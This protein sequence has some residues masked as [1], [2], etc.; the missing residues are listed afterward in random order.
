MIKNISLILLILFI[1]SQQKSR[2]AELRSR[3]I[4]S[5]EERRSQ[6]RSYFPERYE[7]YLGADGTPNYRFRDA[8]DSYGPELPFNINI[9]ELT[10]YPFKRVQINHKLDDGWLVG[11]NFGEWGGGLFWFNE[12]GDEH[13]RLRFGTIQRIISIGSNVYILQGLDQV[14]GDGRILKLEKKDRWTVNTL[15]ELNDTPYASFI[16]EN[17]ELIIAATENIILVNTEFEAEPLIENGF[18]KYY[19]APNSVIIH[20]DILYVGMSEG[21]LK[22]PLNNLEKMEWLTK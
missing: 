4:P 12:S 19:A 7:V 13:Y 1:N 11:F 18:W 15:L 5:K 16:T 3:S 9:E 21:I 22:T 17:N 14:R 8:P 6:N 2:I 20:D 10:G